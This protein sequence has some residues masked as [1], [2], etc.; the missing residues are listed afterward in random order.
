MMSA[1]L[2]KVKCSIAIGVYHPACLPS[3]GVGPS[4]A[5]IPHWIGDKQQVPCDNMEKQKGAPPLRVW[6]QGEQVLSHR[7]DLEGGVGLKGSRR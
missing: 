2:K 1:W 7:R 6:R 4:R 5:P 3:N